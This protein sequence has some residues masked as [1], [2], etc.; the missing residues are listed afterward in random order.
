VI[1]FN[2]YSSEVE[3]LE[4]HYDNFKEEFGSILHRQARKLGERG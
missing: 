1:A 4:M 2:K 3:R